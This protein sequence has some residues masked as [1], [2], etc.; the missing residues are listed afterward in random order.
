MD[1]I[2]I[3]KKEYKKLLSQ[4]KAYQKL[5]NGFFENV[6]KDP[7]DDVIND[8][9]KNGLYSNEFLKELGNGLRKSTYIKNRK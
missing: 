7:V 3:P 6:V 8:F 9:K 1:T 4:A 5:T 2:T